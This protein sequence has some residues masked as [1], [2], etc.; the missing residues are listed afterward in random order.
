MAWDPVEK[1]RSLLGDT[2]PTG[3]SADDQFFSDTDL[4]NLLLDAGQNMNRAAY[5]GWRMKAAN[6]AELINVTEGN[7]M[8]NMSD[9]H[10]HAMAMVTHFSK[11]SSDASY[12]RTRVG[13]IRRGFW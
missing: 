9:L 11:A 4:S 7:A 12:G 2:I 3:G 10:G 1:L 6:Y 5:E 8:R 13:R